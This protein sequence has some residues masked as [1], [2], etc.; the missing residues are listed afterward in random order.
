[1]QTSEN[2]EKLDAA[3][4]K[5][6]AELENPS[7]DAVNPHFRSKYATLDTGLNV[8]R[9][10]LSKH[11]ISMTQPTG[12]QDGV[13]IL[14]TRLAC[15]G[16]WIQSEYPV[17]AF[18][19]K[20]QEMGSNMTY[21][22]RYSLFSLVGIAGEEDDDGNAA[23]TPTSAPKKKEPSLK[24]KNES[25]ALRVDMTEE[26]VGCKTE[27]ALLDWAEKT[28]PTR[29][30]MQPDDRSELNKVYTKQLKEIKEQANG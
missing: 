8:V 1:M 23:V 13:L 6:Q 20:A 17:C 11:G 27:Q 9:K 10:T 12:F 7:K 28:S 2:T 26:I 4:A 3:L 30:L 21:S 19:I 18:P 24:D 22:R 25:E 15:Q 14:Y 5:A 29:K 16:Q